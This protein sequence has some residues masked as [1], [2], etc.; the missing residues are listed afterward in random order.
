[1]KTKDLVKEITLC[2][3][4]QYS[5]RHKNNKSFFKKRITNNKTIMTEKDLTDYRNLLIDLEAQ[6]RIIREE[7]YKG[8]K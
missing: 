8:E 6:V 7:M 1:M 4:K 2:F 5:Q 3:Q